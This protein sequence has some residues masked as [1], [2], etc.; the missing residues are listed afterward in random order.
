M[1]PQSQNMAIA[2]AMGH[3]QVELGFW[4]DDGTWTPHPNGNPTGIWNHCRVN[5][6]DC[7]NDL[8]AMAVA[9]KECLA[10]NLGEYLIFLEQATF[11]KPACPH[12]CPSDPDRFALVHATAAQR[13][14][15]LLKTLKLWNP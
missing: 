1:S 3:T 9:E 5:I 8:N 13:L 4:E 14:E 2:T 15:A 7:H 6:I 11:T 12:A 10:Y